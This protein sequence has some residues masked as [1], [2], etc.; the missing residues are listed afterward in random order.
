MSKDRISY[1]KP[2]NISRS[3]KVV[4]LPPEWAR[5][6]TGYVRVVER[7]DGV[8]ELSIADAEDISAIAQSGRRI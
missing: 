8:V 7:E 5:R 3:S 1:R 2:F 6:I 4:T